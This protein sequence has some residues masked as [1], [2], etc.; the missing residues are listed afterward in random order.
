MGAHS[1]S[2]CSLL[3]GNRCPGVPTILLGVPLPMA[4]KRDALLM[5]VRWTE[6]YTRRFRE[7]ERASFALSGYEP[8]AHR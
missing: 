6:E 2:R 7:V 1:M 5:I 4:S 3:L 8:R